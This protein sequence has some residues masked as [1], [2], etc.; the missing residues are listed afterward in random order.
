M[1]A[2]PISPI[3]YYKSQWHSINNGSA[4]SASLDVAATPGLSWVSITD[5]DDPL[6]R[7]VIQWI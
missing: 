5:L 4:V 3:N 6:I 1:V 2:R 7:M